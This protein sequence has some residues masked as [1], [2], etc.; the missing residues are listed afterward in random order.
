MRLRHSTRSRTRPF[1][2][3][4]ATAL[5]LALASPGILPNPTQASGAYAAAPLAHVRYIQHGLTVQA[6]RARAGKGKVKQSLFK[7][8]ALQTRRKEKASIT[9]QDSTL[10]H[11]NQLTSA[12]LRSAALTQ[13]KSGEVEEQVVPGSNHSVQTSAAVASA[14]GTVFDVLVR[15]KLTVITVVE[16]AVLVQTAHGTVLVKSGQQVRITKGTT[17]PQPAPA[18]IGAATSWTQSIP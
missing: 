9:F 4:G 11:M 16:G 17:P 2:L 3:L 8:Y 6:P 14:V 10:L 13:L 18:N 15:G 7:S 5:L 1:A 12:V